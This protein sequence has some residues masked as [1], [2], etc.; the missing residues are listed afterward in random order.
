[1]E[2]VNARLKM[3]WG[4]GDGNVVGSHRFCAHVGAVPG[5][6]LA[7]ATLLATAQRHEGSFGG[8]KLTPIGSKLRE[9]T[10]QSAV[11]S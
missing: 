11:I 4:L 8:M 2:R 5:I 6:H 9:L 3:F 7:S 1:M 10:G